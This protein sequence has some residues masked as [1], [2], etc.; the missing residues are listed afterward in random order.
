MR[1][2]S[3]RAPRS[4]DGLVAG[5]DT[6]IPRVLVVGRGN[7]LY[8]AGWCYHPHHRIVQLHVVA[9]GGVHP[10]K[11][12]AMAR[13]AAAAVSDPTRDP[14]GHGLRSTFWA[15][16]P[17]PERRQPVRTGLCLRA[18]LSDGSVRAKRIGT[19]SLEPGRARD[20]CDPVS[21]P[22]VPGKPL[23]AICMATCNPPLE[24]FRRQVLS[25]R[26]QT[27]PHWVCIISDD[28]S[29]PDV[30]EAIRGIAL[31]DSRF[32]VSRTPSTLGFYHNF[33]RCLSLVPNDVEFIALCDQDDWWHPDKLATL[34]SHCDERT[35]LVYSDMRIV[36]RNGRVVSDTYWTTRPNRYDDLGS[37]VIANTVTGAASMFRRSL[38]D[39]VLP[40][41][42]QVGRSFH[43]HWIAAV[44]VAVGTMRY[45]GR[46]LH[47]YVQHAGNVVGYR[48]PSPRGTVRRLLRY[49]ARAQAVYFEEVV[50][51]QLMARVLALRCGRMLSAERRRALE[52]IAR[53]DESLGA[54]TWLALRGVQRLW[55]VTETLG[56]ECVLLVGI[57]WRWHLWA[58]SLLPPRRRG[59]ARRRTAVLRGPR[60][61]VGP[62]GR[63]P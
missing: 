42:Q 36:D 6:A 63:D 33:E 31:R 48:A 35:M 2:L 27:Y 28:G 17:F 55:R 40:F 10:V 34:L 38:L 23:V 60:S 26:D 62:L 15:L 50:R 8:L 12:F 21:A 4:E 46:P 51:A 19:I 45:V 47:D 56:I 52:R 43:D 61:H 44:A 22:R 53:S 5:V 24:L 18:R 25:I 59:A 3:P 30:F 14:R 57:L 58:R 9:D 20:A 41:P 37:L 32:R 11:A 29:P 13:P 39:Y 1:S 7:V 54:M 49:V 16:V